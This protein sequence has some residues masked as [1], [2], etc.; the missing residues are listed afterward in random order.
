MAA[1]GPGG[2]SPSFSSGK[3]WD[4]HKEIKSLAN[5]LSG[6]A[7]KLVLLEPIGQGGFGTVYRGRWRNLEVAVK[8]VLFRSV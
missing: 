8:T 7:N 4:P 6:E 3:T 2:A 1:E 5:N